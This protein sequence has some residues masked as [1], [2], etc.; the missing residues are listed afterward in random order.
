MYISTVGHS[1]FI[2]STIPCPF[3]FLLFP[4]TYNS[5]TQEHPGP[6]WMHTADS[7]LT[8]HFSAIFK[9]CFLDA[10]CWLILRCQTYTKLLRTA[11][12][13][14]FLPMDSTEAYQWVQYDLCQVTGW[15]AVVLTT[16]QFLLSDLFED[17]NPA[18]G[19][20]M[21]ACDQRRTRIVIR[22]TI[23]L[24]W[25][26]PKLLFGVIHS[27]NLDILSRSNRTTEDNEYCFSPLCFSALTQKDI[28]FETIKIPFLIT[29]SLLFFAFIGIICLN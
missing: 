14:Q 24:C 27:V 23:K 10:S 8:E 17:H 4:R 6:H 21:S 19:R 13:T 29:L 9:C 26:Q 18:S 12:H 5:T 1:L 11:Q 3:P 28:L 7:G 15:K 22:K 25:T 2:G 16:V 20:L